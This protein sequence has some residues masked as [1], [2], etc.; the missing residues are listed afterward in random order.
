MNEIIETEEKSTMWMLSEKES[1]FSRITQLEEQVGLYT[2]IN[3]VGFPT[4][5]AI[6]E[7]V[8]EIDMRLDDVEQ[9]LITVETQITE[10]NNRLVITDSQITEIL[11]ILKTMIEQ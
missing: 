6:A 3:G 7:S 10:M 5:E 1:I 9:R 11:Q 8:E 4:V 2:D